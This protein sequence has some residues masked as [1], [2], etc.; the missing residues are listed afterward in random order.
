MKVQKAVMQEFLPKL[1]HMTK[2]REDVVAAMTA[3]KEQMRTAAE[4]KEDADE[5]ASDCAFEEKE[6]EEE[7]VR[8]SNRPALGHSTIARRDVSGA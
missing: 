4:E 7:R 1:G 3:M 8:S 6:M 5:E 2:E